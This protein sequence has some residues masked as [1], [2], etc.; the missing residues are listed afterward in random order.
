MKNDFEGLQVDYQ[1]SG[2]QHNQGDT[3]VQAAIAG[4]G[5]EQAPDSV[6]DGGGHDINVTMGVNSADGNGNI[7]AYLGYRQINAV[8]MSERDFSACALRV[9]SVPEDVCGGSDVIPTDVM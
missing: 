4:V 5:Y 1:Y 9:F 8:T 7:T 6:W 2:Y 3:S